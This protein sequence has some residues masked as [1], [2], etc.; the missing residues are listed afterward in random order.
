MVEMEQYNNESYDDASSTYGTNTNS[1]CNS[2]T[3]SSTSSDCPGDMSFSDSGR[4][5]SEDDCHTK[6]KRPA[7]SGKLKFCFI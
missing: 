1:S 2:G 6:L 7:P 5:T 3:E 4:G